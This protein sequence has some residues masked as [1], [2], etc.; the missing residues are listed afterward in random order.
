M[1]KVNT[2]NWGIKFLTTIPKT[3]R[4]LNGEVL[5]FYFK[6]QILKQFVCR[7][8]NSTLAPLLTFEIFQ[9]VCEHALATLII[10]LSH[11]NCECIS[12]RIES[13]IHTRSR[14]C[15]LSHCWLRLE[16]LY[17]RNNAPDW[18]H[19]K[20]YKWP[21]N[22]SKLMNF[23][24]ALPHLKMATWHHV[25]VQAELIGVGA[26]IHKWIPAKSQAPACNNET[27]IDHICAS[28]NVSA[29][30]NS[31]SVSWVCQNWLL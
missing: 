1:E 17:P 7:F 23:N 8:S 3:S 13:K 18:S 15:P 21:M 29:R 24:P 30:L 27:R 6:S 2:E 4:N 26:I 5:I 16:H 19:Q 31:C 22:K 11:L 20:I 25:L 12:Y 10:S 14:D 9:I 28:F